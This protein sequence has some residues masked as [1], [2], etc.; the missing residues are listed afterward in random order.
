MTT[1]YT[2]QEFADRVRLQAVSVR[3]TLSRQGHVCGVV[4]VKLPNRRV[5]WPVEKVEALLREPVAA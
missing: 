3:S 1:H 5:L 2:T 4:P